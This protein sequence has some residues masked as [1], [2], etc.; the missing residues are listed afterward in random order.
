MK[1][2]YARTGKRTMKG[3]IDDAAK[4]AVREYKQ[5]F[6]DDNKQGMFPLKK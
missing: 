5:T 3:M 4:S 1:A 2:E 6:S